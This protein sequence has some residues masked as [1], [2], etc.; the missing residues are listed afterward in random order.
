MDHNVVL[1]KTVHCKEHDMPKIKFTDTVVARD[2][3]CI[4]GKTTWYSDTE[5]R[6]LQLCVTA[7]GA[8]TWY[9]NRWDPKAEKTRRVKIGPFASKGTHT[10]WAREQAQ[11]KTLDV[12]EGRVQTREERA[13]ERSGVP[14][15]REA[16]DR[17]MQFRQTRGEAYGGPIHDKTANDYTRAFE[18]YLATWADQKMD[19]IDVSAIQRALDDLS[20]SK[21]FAAHKVNIVVGMTFDRASRMIGAP[22]QVL[23]P[24]LDSNRSRM[25]PSG[26]RIGKNTVNE[27][28]SMKQA[29]SPRIVS[30]DAPRA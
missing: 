1:A 2:C 27:S 11:K 20:E 9:L 5:T 10:R 13:V 29:S 23:T 8:K 24:K 28:S 26:L 14:T 15:L 12:I 19:E 4:D 30:A 7:R 22:L 16:F 6:G 25:R 3:V 21:P 17:E 18:R